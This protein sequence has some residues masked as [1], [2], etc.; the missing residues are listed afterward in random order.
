MKRTISAVILSLIVAATAAAQTP[1]PAAATPAPKTIVNLV[2][3]AIAENDFRKAEQ[4]ARADM[5]A[6]GRTPLAI[7]AFSWLGRGLD[8]LCLVIVFGIFW[9]ATRV[10]AGSRGFT[11]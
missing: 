6:L 7:E 2:R 4:L 9:V 10:A 5:K 3:D 1:A 11:A 8:A